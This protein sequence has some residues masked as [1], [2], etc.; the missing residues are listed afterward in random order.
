[1]TSASEWRGKAVKARL[2][3]S[4]YLAE[5][6]EH[7]AEMVAS[8]PPEQPPRPVIDSDAGKGFPPKPRPGTSEAGLLPGLMAE[9]EAW[10]D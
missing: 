10:G 8:A 6:Y 1:M 2:A 7:E 4:E 9:R 3:G 5:L